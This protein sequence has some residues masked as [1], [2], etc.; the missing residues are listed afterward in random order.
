MILAAA[1]AICAAS[2][3]WPDGVDPAFVTVYDGFATGFVVPEPRQMTEPGQP[4]ILLRAGQPQTAIFVPPNAPAP[5]KYAAAELSAQAG[6]LATGR[7]RRHLPALPIR[8]AS[9]PQDGPAILICTRS[10]SLPRWLSALQPAIRRL[11]AEGYVAW[12]SA[13]QKRAAV[14]GA[15]ARGAYYGVQSLLQLMRADGDAVSLP[16]IRIVDW[17]S[18]RVRSHQFDG[19]FPAPERGRFALAW[20][21]KLKLNQ[22]G[23]GQAYDRPMQWRELNESQQQCVGQ[24]G[25]FANAVGVID[26]AFYAHPHRSKPEF[27]ILISRQAD[28]DA[29]AGICTFALGQGCRAVMLRSDDIHPLAPEDKQRFG[30]KAAAHIHMVNFLYNALR[31]VEPSVRFMFCPPYYTNASIRRAPDGEDYIRRLGRSTPPEVHVIW[32]GPVTRSLEIKPQDVDYIERLL[33]RCPM[34][35]DNTVYAHR[36]RYGYDPRHPHYFF[37]TFQTKY[38]SDFP[39]RSPGITYNWAAGSWIALVGAINTADYLWNPEAYDPERSLRRALAVVAGEDFV[40]TLLDIREAYYA[41][42]DAVTAQAAG[43]GQ[44]AEVAAASKRLEG[45]AARLDRCPNR[46]LAREVQNRIASI[47]RRA[48]GLLQV[49]AALE[50]ARSQ[51]L[52]AVSLQPGR[53]NLESSGAWKGSLQHNT[54][55]ASVPAGTPSPAGSFAAATATIPA[56]PPSPTGRY[57]LVFSA[58]DSYTK[59]GT[60]RSA[61]PGYIFKQALVNG[62]VVWEDDVEGAE[63]LQVCGFIATDITYAVSAGKPVTITLR[64]FCKRAIHNMGVSITFSA[65]AICPGPF[66]LQSQLGEIPCYDGLSGQRFTMFVRF[67]ISRIGP[68]QAIFA[69]TPPFEYFCYVRETGQVGA[70]IFASG[71]EVSVLSDAK[72]S[73]GTHSVALRHDG[74]TITLF[75]DGKTA[76]SR[77]APPASPSRANL[78]LGF[79]SGLSI[80]LRGRILYAAFW[81]DALSDGEIAR[82]AAGQ[83]VE[84]KPSGAWDLSKPGVWTAENSAGGPACSIYRLYQ[85]AGR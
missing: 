28:L 51:A 82:L 62:R 16:S 1:M 4:M 73:P 14:V 61:W 26:A 40:Q 20:A 21:A 23:F 13:G 19:S 80:P 63:P 56:L 32:T 17:P 60:P 85:P 33:G 72:I 5:I 42:F 44:V 58:S 8:S 10:D 7:K 70:G 31:R 55:T 9:P 76:A 43:V 84:P 74:S 22:L 59:H 11:P 78:L 37:D 68:R 18:Y 83:Q 49:G 69:K 3:A 50:Q 25:A 15:D 53:C 81:Q 34:L 29:L 75:I 67:E 30:D 77:Q 45:L 2:A 79:Y 47:R 27:N 12:V 6:F 71:R 54:F 46:E 52:A 41:I 57:W 39:R 64:G 35:W 24:M 66:S 48:R 65:P 38:P 36:S